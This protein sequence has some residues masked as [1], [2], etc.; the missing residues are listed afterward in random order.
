MDLCPCKVVGMPVDF[1]LAL[2]KRA[3]H[4]SLR[5]KPPTTTSVSSHGSSH[6][7]APGCLLH[8]CAILFSFK[9]TVELLFKSKKHSSL[10]AVIEH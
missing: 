4:E 3:R 9:N 10:A 5:G 6:K 7:Q 1:L 2:F 8:P